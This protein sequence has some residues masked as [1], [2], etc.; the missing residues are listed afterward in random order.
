MVRKVK[1]IPARTNFTIS[2]ESI[3]LIVDTFTGKPKRTLVKRILT[4][5][6]R[7]NSVGE[8]DGGRIIVAD[9]NGSHLVG[10]SSLF[11][12][13]DYLTNDSLVQP[14]PAD[15]KNFLEYGTDKF[16]RKMF[17][18]AKV[19]KLLNSDQKATQKFSYLY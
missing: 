17:N 13:L 10:S 2:D 1:I 5:L 4:H 14:I 12:I 19:K 18:E 7:L 11:E 3:H 15:T 8:D 9:A 6:Q 16:L